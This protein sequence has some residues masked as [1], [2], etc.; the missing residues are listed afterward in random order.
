MMSAVEDSALPTNIAS[1]DGP[2]KL[3]QERALGE[4]CVS[5][6]TRIGFELEFAASSQAIISY[7]GLYCRC[8]FLCQAPGGV[9]TEKGQRSWSTCTVGAYIYY[10]P[11]GRKQNLATRTGSSVDDPLFKIR[12]RTTVSH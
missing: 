11:G 5:G 4:E 7:S 2:T 10:L 3:P 1:P 6:K 12:V 8:F 9:E